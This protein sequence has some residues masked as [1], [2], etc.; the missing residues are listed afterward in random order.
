[1]KKKLTSAPGALTVGILGYGEV[2]QAIASLYE[3]APLVCDLERNDFTALKEECLDVLHVC[4]PYSD[5]FVDLVAAHIRAY[6]RQAVVIIHAT[7]PPG[8][9]EAVRAQAGD[10]GIG[11]VHSPVRGVHPNLAAGLT[12][13]VKYVGADAPAAGEYAAAHLETL[14][15]ATAILYKSRTTELMKLLDTTYYGLCIAFHAYAAALCEE[16]RVNMDMVMKHANL[17]Y[18][19][20]YRSLKKPTVVRP[21]L[22]P[23]KD[24]KIGGHC[25][26]PNALLLK[27]HYGT[28]PLLEAIIRHS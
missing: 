1:M 15:M 4:M 12:T 7:V 10:N 13:F 3:K 14:G 5:T 17:S 18:N 9:T 8:T 22:Y 21:V 26:V 28:D 2:G 6:A 11:V 16:E 27:E 23:P 25:V 20:G 24:G 19:K